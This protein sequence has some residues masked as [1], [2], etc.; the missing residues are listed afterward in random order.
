MKRLTLD[1]IESL[2]QTWEAGTPVDVDQANHAFEVLAGT[3]DVR[4]SGIWLRLNTIAGQAVVKALRG[5]EYWIAADGWN[6]GPFQTREK[7]E[8][9]P[10]GFRQRGRA[11]RSNHDGKSEYGHVDPRGPSPDQRNPPSRFIRCPRQRRLSRCGDR[12]ERSTSREPAPQGLSA[13]AF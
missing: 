2:I 7:A 12:E 3:A 5:G 13:K 10:E 4:V 6:A 9:T 8:Q 1:E 11:K